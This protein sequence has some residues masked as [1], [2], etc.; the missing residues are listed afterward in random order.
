MIRVIITS[1]IIIK[2]LKSW[3]HSLSSTHIGKT[4]NLRSRREMWDFSRPSLIISQTQKKY[5]AECLVVV[6]FSLGFLFWFTPEG[7]ERPMKWSHP[8]LTGPANELGWGYLQARGCTEHKQPQG[9]STT[10]EE[11]PPTVSRAYVP[12][13]GHSHTLGVLYSSTME[14]Q[15]IQSW[16]FPESSQPLCIRDRSSLVMPRGLSSKNGCLRETVC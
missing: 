13:L 2:W 3:E 15:R 1:H 9:I 8:S 7:N 11:S 10:Q 6:D 12:R 5:S 14:C 4:Y 16:V